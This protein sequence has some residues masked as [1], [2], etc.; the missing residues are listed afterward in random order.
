MDRLR[1]ACILLNLARGGLPA[2][3]PEFEP[4]EILFGSSERLRALG[5]E[6]G[7][8]ERLL[9]LRA[10]GEPLLEQE[11]AAASGTRILIPGDA[12]FPR[13]LLEHPHRPPVLYLR[14]L[15]LLDPPRAAIV[16]ARTASRAMERFSS[17]LGEACAKA[18]V[19]VVSGLARGIDAAAHAGCLKADGFPVGVL[20]TGV[21]VIYPRETRRLH[22]AVEASG[23]ILSTFPLGAQPKPFHFPRRNRIVAALADR[24]VVVQATEDSGSISTARAALDAGTEVCAVPGSPDDPL[25]RGANQLLRDGAAPILEP[26]DLL[27]PLVGVGVCPREERSPRVRKRIDKDTRIRL[28][29][30]STPL[31]A[32]ELA[33]VTS[34]PLAEVLE[35]LICMEAEGKVERIPGR[36]FLRREPNS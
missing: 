17:R 24:V 25:A 22:A 12:E 35:R 18:G 11:R 14:G 6:P 10:R 15:P 28:Q 29:I 1:R 31:T 8:V 32:E 2:N 19:P 36:L 30:G 9:A 26:A 13:C 27:D 5:L 34:L 23:S 21:D 4:R 3:T 7:T 16:G 20:G 33:R